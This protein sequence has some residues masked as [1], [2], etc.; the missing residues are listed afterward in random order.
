VD[1][2]LMATVLHDLAQ[3]G[4]AKGALGETVRV[5]R[6]EGRL[7]VV[8]FVKVDGPPGPPRSVRISPEELVEV[9]G[10]FGFREER[11]VETGPSTYLSTFQLDR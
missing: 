9:V 1:A 5:L 8:E 7:H 4:T 6:P 2:V 11:S 3:V 10:P